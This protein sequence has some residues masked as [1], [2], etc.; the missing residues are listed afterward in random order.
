MKSCI[1][2]CII[3]MHKWIVA[4]KAYVKSDA[5]ICAPKAHPNLNNY[6]ATEKWLVCVMRSIVILCR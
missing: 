6:N 1:Q 4:C 5:K 3:I 2:I